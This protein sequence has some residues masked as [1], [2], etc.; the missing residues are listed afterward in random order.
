MVSVHTP[1]RSNN[2]QQQALLRYCAEFVNQIGLDVK[3]E[4]G[5]TGFVPGVKIVDGALRYDLTSALP[6]DLLHEAGHLAVL[7]SALRACCNVDVDLLSE[8]IYN[9]LQ[10][11]QACGNEGAKRALLQCG[12]QEATAWAWAVG[13]HLGL[14]VKSIIHDDA[15]EEVNGLAGAASVRLALSVN[16]YVG[17]NGL[18]AAGWC[19]VRDNA[20]SRMRGLPVF[21]RLNRWLAA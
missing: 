4:T 13:V 17:I 12:E 14:P 15:Y 20:L 10:A 5:A 2:S 18:E 8:K 1:M 21:P 9:A 19:A 3:E 6:G 16:C 11:A 7:P